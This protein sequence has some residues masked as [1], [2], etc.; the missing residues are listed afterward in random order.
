MSD[1]EYLLPT[2]SAE[3]QKIVSATESILQQCSEMPQE[4]SCNYL[5]FL[6][7]LAEN[8]EEDSAKL[9]KLEESE[10]SFIDSALLLSSESSV[11]PHYSK[12]FFSPEEIEE[13]S[14]QFDLHTQIT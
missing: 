11:E 7:C 6:D 1:Q 13:F 14:N 10:K 8:H 12:Y 9:I 4:F 2:N 5:D 3:P